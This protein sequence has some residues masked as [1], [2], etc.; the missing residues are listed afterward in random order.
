VTQPVAA[1][2]YLRVST[3]GQ[4][5]DGNGLALQESACRAHAAAADLDLVGVFTERGVSGD[6]A[7]RPALAQALAMIKSGDA[8]AILVCRLDRLARDLVLQE[9]LLK[10]ENELLR[11]CPPPRARTSCCATPT[12]R[13]AS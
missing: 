4:A 12:T 9:I 3:Q 6:K 10:G 8:D 5:E 11:C 2:A 13:P 7:E 1:A